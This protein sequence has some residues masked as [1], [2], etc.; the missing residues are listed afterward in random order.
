MK[1]ED[2]INLNVS[3]A[4]ETELKE[5]IKVLG[6]AV[7]R[8]ATNLR[9]EANK[10]GGAYSPALAN[11]EQMYPAGTT[12]K[13]PNEKQYFATHKQSTNSQY[14]DE[15][16][17]VVAQGQRWVQLKTS[18]VKGTKEWRANVEKAV[19]ENIDG[20]TSWS[21]DQKNEFWKLI[22][23][24][25]NSDVS[26]GVY[27]N[28]GSDVVMNFVAQIVNN[29]SG[30]ALTASIQKL[31]SGGSTGK[32]ATAKRKEARRL[33]KGMPKD[34]MLSH[35][36]DAEKSFN[37]VITNLQEVWDDMYGMQEADPMEL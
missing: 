22:N 32:S 5:A 11:L 9:I 14:V 7:R 2:A 19:G 21:T 35:E 15:L 37:S 34:I 26:R 18:T 16:R 6:R 36:G 29:N 13:V 1:L 27:A 4:S 25:K 24:I 33:I 23:K 17:K 12:Y 28:F 31:V 10:E 8:R 20:Y 30:S 3:T